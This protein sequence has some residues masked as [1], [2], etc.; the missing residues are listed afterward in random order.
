M[1]TYHVNLTNLQ[2]GLVLAKNN[3]LDKNIR[4]GKFVEIIN[5]SVAETPLPL[6]SQEGYY[7]KN[8]ITIINSLYSFIANINNIDEVTKNAYKN[9]DGLTYPG[10]TQIVKGERN[11]DSD[12]VKAIKEL[13]S[14][15][16]ISSLRES[17]SSNE[18]A[19][20]KEAVV[21]KIH[22]F[23]NKSILIT[24]KDKHFAQLLNKLNNLYSERDFDGFLSYYFYYVITISPNK[25]NINKEVNT[26]NYV[27]NRMKECIASD[28][29]Y[30]Y[31]H[32][33]H[34]IYICKQNK[35]IRVVKTEVFESYF[36]PP[37]NPSAKFF[38]RPISFLHSEERDNHEIMQFIINGID[39]SDK[40]IVKQEDNSGRLKYKKRFILPDIPL[41][42]KYRVKIISESIEKFPVYEMKF[43]LLSPSK[44]LKIS[45]TINSEEDSSNF[46]DKWR[47]SGSFFTAFIKELERNGKNQN[48]VETPHHYSVE[49]FEWLP[50]GV[51]YHLRVR[52]KDNEWKDVFQLTF[53]E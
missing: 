28:E 7:W 34:D 40:I 13:S 44:H 20:P 47:V 29:F 51:G 35:T 27:T 25:I 36:L 2:E 43:T 50:A 15:E 12:I 45:A 52:P 14:K 39:Y 41:A 31:H 23:V 22:V 3:I 53:S 48:V 24:S 37:Y 4:F 32:R 16:V 26:L 30:E 6:F 8:Q 11:I 42:Y 17:F 19:F 38:E 46:I 33:H 1:S 49:C 5:K 10:I 9:A 18:N 21:E